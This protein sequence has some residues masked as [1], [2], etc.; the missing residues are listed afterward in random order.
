MTYK[1]VKVKKVAKTDSELARLWQE[2]ICY[3]PK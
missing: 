3:K 1:V 2:V